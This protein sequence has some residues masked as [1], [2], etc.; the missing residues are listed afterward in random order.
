MEHPVY[1][2]WR[3]FFFLFH[4]SCAFFQTSFPRCLQ[5]FASIKKEKKKKITFPTWNTR[6]HEKKFLPR[7]NVSLKWME[8]MEQK[9]NL[10]TRYRTIPDFD[11]NTLFL[12][13]QRYRVVLPIFAEEKKTH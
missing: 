4:I 3:F 6:F 8:W 9:W 7:F 5:T 13:L 10:V 1:V 12:I 11:E 2:Q